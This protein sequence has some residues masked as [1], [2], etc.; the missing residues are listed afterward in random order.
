MASRKTRQAASAVRLFPSNIMFYVRLGNFFR[1]KSLT[2]NLGERR[3][4]GRIEGISRTWRAGQGAGMVELL[5]VTGWQFRGQR[6]ATDTEGHESNEEEDPF[7]HR[8]NK[9]RSSR[10]A[11]RYDRGA[12]SSARMRVFFPS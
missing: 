3:F 12:S 2:R 11:N 6:G 10:P 1:C 4:I 8:G 5:L 7:D 9:A